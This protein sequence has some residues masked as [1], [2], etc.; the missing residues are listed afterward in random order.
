ML[1][2]RL[3]FLQARSFDLTYKFKN[4]YKNGPLGGRFFAAG[5]L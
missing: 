5:Y 4:N 1:Q 2:V 3:L